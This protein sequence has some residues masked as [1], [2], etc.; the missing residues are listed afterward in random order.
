MKKL[1]ASLLVLVLSSSIAIAHAQQKN[2]TIKTKEIEGVVVTALGIKREKKSLGYASQEIKG[3]MISDAGQTNA[4]SALSGNVAGVQVTAPSTM[5]G[6]TR[7]TMRGIS[8]ITGENRPLII[9]DGVPLDNSN[10][11]DIDTQRGAGGRDYGD[12]SFDI[13]P[14]DIESVTV[15]KGGPA[16]ALYGS[17]AGNGAILYTTKS[18]KKGRTDIQLNTGVAFESIY[19]RP[20]LQNQYGGG[21]SATLPTANINGQ[22]YNIQEYETDASWG[23]KY[24]SNLMYLPWYAFDP[25]FSSDYLKPVPWVAPK[26][27][28]DSFFDTGVTYTNNLSVAK[29]FG[30]TN[31]RL[32]YT[33][34]NIGGI[35]PTS[36]IKKD[37]FSI[38]LNSKLSDNLKA[39]AIFNYV[40]TDGYNRPELGYGDNSV[41][42]KFYQFGQRNLDFVKLKDYKLSNGGQ[43]TWNR[44]AWNDPTP[45]YSD[46]PY[47]IINEN[48][49]EDSRHR[50]FGNAGLTYNFN[51]NFYIV[52]KVYG[53]V[54]SQ[55][56]SSRVAVGSQ[57]VSDYTIEKRNVSEFNYEGRAHY[58]N[59]FGDFSVNSFVGFNIR[60]NK[61]SWLNGT[62]VGGLVI[63]NLYNLNNGVENSLA[64][65]ASIHSSVKSLF[66]SVSLGY[67]DMLFVEATGRNDWFSSVNDDQ[68]YPSITGSFVF[69]KALSIDWLSFGKVRAGW[70]SIASGGDAYKRLTYTVIGIPFNGAPQYSNPNTNNDPNIRPEVKTTK[71]F[72]I[73]ASFFKNRFGFDVTYYDTK[74]KDLILP[75]PIDPATG[76][77]FKNINVGEMTNKG[78][79]AMVNVSPIRNDNFSWDI[80]WNFAKNKNKLVELQ[81]DLKNHILTNAPFRAQLAA[82]VGEAYGAILGTDYVYDANGNRVV[83]A[84][85]FY[86]ASDLKSLGSILPDYNMG[87]RNTVKYKSLS[88][89]F[90]IDIQQGGKYFST[91][92]MWGMYSGMLE[93]SALGGNRE[94]GVILDGVKEDGTKNDI[95]LDAPTWGGTYYNTVDAQNVF[96]ASYIKLRDVT[97]GY[98]L[99]KSLIGNVFQGIRISAFARNLFAWNLAN[100]GIDPENTSYGSGNIQGMEGGSLP[101]TRTYGFNVNFKF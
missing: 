61:M 65:N 12:A 69:S 37:N 78:I 73:E 77:L 43:R 28:V 58:N 75:L 2:D 26:N 21:Y 91:T 68:F 31:V 13:N 41:A 44:T 35:V 81:G 46:N 10:V 51:K 57:A 18:A 64:T 84:N 24:D 4:V 11:N 42:Q 89:S 50:F 99:P 80:T 14:D 20:K 40:H 93:E 6:S 100:K 62:T 56:I 72:G 83:D 33:N 38:N 7:I 52:G 76:F 23:P 34:T 92:H 48:T 17:R 97:I 5:G 82:Q 8:S 39:E 85:G 87:F 79:E 70:S 96:D 45:L 32:S 29:S 101:S 60:D 22:T 88:L 47:W 55:N 49:S 25:E 63:P 36:K 16:A 9:V 1:T 74:S 19:I 66:G 71:E 98:D 15:L 90:L 30:D 3:D 67:K 27:D 59:N 94:A 53:D 86:K 95:L 54:Y